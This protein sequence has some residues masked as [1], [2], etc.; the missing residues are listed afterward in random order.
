MVPPCS[1][2]PWRSPAIHQKKPN[3]FNVEKPQTPANGAY[4]FRPSASREGEVGHA[5]SAYILRLTVLS[6]LVAYVCRPLS[7]EGSASW[8]RAWMICLQRQHSR[9]QPR[10]SHPAA[11][12]GLRTVYKNSPS[13]A[14]VPARGRSVLSALIGGALAGIVEIEAGSAARH[15]T[16]FPGLHTVHKN[17]RS[18]AGLRARDRFVLSAPMGGALAGIAEIAARSAARI[19]SPSRASMRYARIRGR[20]RARR[21]HLVFVFS[22]LMGETLAGIAEIRAVRRSP[23]TMVGPARWPE[24]QPL[25]FRRAPQVPKCAPSTAAASSL[26][27]SPCCRKRVSEKKPWIVPG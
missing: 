22:A 26:A 23:Q 24:F 21:R 12:P 20:R 15:P 17:S 7:L 8:S 10:R 25:T 2:R 13:P 4:L 14:R 6:N 9:T 5:G 27:L 19:R 18:P 3:L 1:G 16:T 11:F